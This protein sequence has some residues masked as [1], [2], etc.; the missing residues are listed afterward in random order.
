M[1]IIYVFLDEKNIFIFII[2]K[3]FKIESLNF[4]LCQIWS[5]WN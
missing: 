4:M 5:L 3:L 2:K 1:L